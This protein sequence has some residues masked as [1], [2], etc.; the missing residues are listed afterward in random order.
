MVD[1]VK[2]TIL[3]LVHFTNLLVL[4]IFVVVCYISKDLIRNIGK[5]LLIIRRLVILIRISLIFLPSLRMIWDEIISILMAIHNGY[6]LKSDQA[7][8]LSRVACQLFLDP[9]Y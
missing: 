2:G 6:L 5:V 9:L 7:P 8:C 4:L 1:F 3:F